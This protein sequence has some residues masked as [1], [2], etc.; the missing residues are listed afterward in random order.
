MLMTDHLLVISID[1]TSISKIANRNDV[2]RS[3]KQIVKVIREVTSL[4][5]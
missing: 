4:G 1:V 5:K 3:D 2:N